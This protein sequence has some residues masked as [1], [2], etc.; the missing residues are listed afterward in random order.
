MLFAL[1]ALTSLIVTTSSFAQGELQ[2][3]LAST[4]AKRVASFEKQVSA[5]TECRL[6]VLSSP[7]VQKSLAKSVG[8]KI[9][10]C[11]IKSVEGGDIIPP[12]APD[13]LIVGAKAQTVA[14]I[15]YARS[16]KILTI[17]L[18]AD[19][20]R[21]GAPV[22]VVEGKGGVAAILLNLKASSQFELD[23]NASIMKYAETLKTFDMKK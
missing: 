22:G 17:G 20:V 15:N 14:A 11:T 12:Y 4:L 18:N 6:Y 9:G 8:K 2:P 21:A 13:V 7:E 23:W 1:A 10:T 5:K 3:A 19:M 16:L